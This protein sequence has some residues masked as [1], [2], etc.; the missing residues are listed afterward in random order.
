[1]YNPPFQHHEG[2]YTLE[3]ESTGRG[4]LLAYIKE[5]DTTEPL[6]L[7]SVNYVGNNPGHT[8][9]LFATA[10]EF[11]RVAYLLLTRD[12][13]YKDVAEAIELAR[14]AMAKYQTEANK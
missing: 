2:P 8:A 13:N 11:Y 7:A 14:E 1:M 6:T 3:F 4:D 12:G 5:A 9:A 10:P